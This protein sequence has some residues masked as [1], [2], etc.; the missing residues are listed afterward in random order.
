MEKWIKSEIAYDGAIIKVRV[1]EVELED[2]TR[3]KREVVEHNGGV[4]VVPFTGHSVI[5][6]RQYRIAVG[7]YVLEIPAGKME[8]RGEDPA[9]RARA[10]L[11]E[12]TGY[13]AGELKYLGYVYCA[14]GFC[15]EKAHLFLGLDMEKVS[16]QNLDHDERIEIVEM[17]IAEIREWVEAHRFIDAKTLLG[18]QALLRHIDQSAAHV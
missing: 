8:S 17:P 5:L 9:M 1:G 14:I 15:T 6:V 7:D 18:C 11:R 2:G 4:G 3:A 12:E 16:G 10:E 13:E